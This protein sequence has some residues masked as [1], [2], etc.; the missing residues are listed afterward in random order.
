MAGG[1]INGSTNNKYISAAIDWSATSNTAENYSDVTATLRY[2]KSSASTAS[3]KGTLSGNIWINGNAKGYSAKVTLSAN[4]S[5]MGIVSHTVRVYHDSNGNASINISASGGISGTTFT[6]T[7]CGGTVGLDAIPRAPSID[8]VTFSTNYL[9]ATYTYKYTPK[10]SSYYNRLRVSVPGIK[11]YKYINLG[12]KPTSQQTGSFSF[13]QDELKLITQENAKTNSETIQLGFVVEA[14]NNSSYTSKIGESGE[15]K[16]DMKIQKIYSP[17]TISFIAEEVGPGGGKYI[18]L[19]S[20]CRFS[21]HVTENGSDISKGT[22][23]AISITGTDGYSYSSSTSDMQNPVNIMGEVTSSVL[24]TPG[25]VDYTLTVTDTRGRTATTKL[26]IVVE[27]YSQPSLSLK[28]YRSD[29]S[30]KRDDAAGKYIHVEVRYT[31]SA[32]LKSSSLHVDDVQKAGNFASPFTKE[33]GEYSLGT[34]HTIKAAVTDSYNN[35]TTTTVTLQVAALPMVINKEKNAMAFGGAAPGEAET[36]RFGWDIKVKHG[37][38][39]YITLLDLLH[40]VG[41][42]IYNSS[43]D[44]D[45]NKYY[46]GTTWVRI[47]GRVLAGVNED[48]KEATGD[49][50]FQSYNQPSGTKIGSRWIDLS[51]AIGAYDNNVASL[52]YLATSRIANGMYYFGLTMTCSHNGNTSGHIANYRINHSTVVRDHGTGLMPDKIQDTQLTYIWE[53]TK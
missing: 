48:D 41:S 35:T 11:A 43:K 31:L 21:Y 29:S 26:S 20:K 10:T 13:S 49:Y 4:N 24:K 45:P 37:S 1:T 2:M 18:K 50:A 51:A 12:Q 32:V 52:G 44:F 38:S 23:A 47:K 6:A 15:A 16:Y 25:V 53:R 27:E 14:H 34:T 42:Q 3:T 19:N 8:S 40:P 39:E 30:G 36:V 9:D 33:Y 46:P 7:N 5:W 28:A 22:I 17:V